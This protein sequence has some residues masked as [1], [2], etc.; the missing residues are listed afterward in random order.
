MVPSIG[1]RWGPFIMTER[2]HLDDTSPVNTPFARLQRYR[3][4]D[5]KTDQIKLIFNTS[6]SKLCSLQPQERV[7]LQWIARDEIWERPILVVKKDGS[8]RAVSLYTGGLCG[9]KNPSYSVAISRIVRQF[10]IPIHP[11]PLPILD[12][13]DGEIWVDFKGKMATTHHHKYWQRRYGKKT[14]LCFNLSKHLK[15]DLRTNVEFYSLV[16]KMA[17]LEG[18]NVSALILNFLSERLQDRHSHLWHVFVKELGEVDG[19]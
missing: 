15:L 8:Q 19:G 12:F 5:R 3:S 17:E 6:A 13:V 16:K 14:K 2:Q 11:F 1:L 10:N 4:P 18:T 9:P 7:D